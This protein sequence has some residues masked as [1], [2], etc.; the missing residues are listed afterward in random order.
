M[1]FV[2]L[3]ILIPSLLLLFWLTIH[4]VLF[5]ITKMKFLKLEKM[6][7]D[8][9]E[10][11]LLNFKGNAVQFSISEESSLYQ[12]IKEKKFIIGNRI[13]KRKMISDSEIKILDIVLS[14]KNEEELNLHKLS[15]GKKILYIFL[16]SFLVLFFL[17]ALMSFITF[18][19]YSFFT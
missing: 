13:S 7:S 15:I 6:T 8:S 9:M 19:F 4:Y 18:I 17:D 11:I 16:K 10:I 1:S 12:K 14:E 3:A 5:P 2:I